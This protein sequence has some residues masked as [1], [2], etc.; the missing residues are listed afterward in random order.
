VTYEEI[1]ALAK[2]R[3]AVKERIPRNM[4]CTHICEMLESTFRAIFVGFYRIHG[5][6]WEGI[7]N[8]EMEENRQLG[9]RSPMLADTCYT[10]NRDSADEEVLARARKKA[11]E[12]K[13]KMAAIEALKRGE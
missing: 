3:N 12:A 2:H 11:D 1:R 10:F 13:M 7:L 4:G 8:L 9:L 5:R 6:K